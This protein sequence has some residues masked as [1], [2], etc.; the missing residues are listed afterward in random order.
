MFQKLAEVQGHPTAI[1]MSH[2]LTIDLVTGSEAAIRTQ[3]LGV[4]RKIVWILKEQKARVDEH[5]FAKRVKHE[6]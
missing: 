3:M 4:V 6:W 2:I 1:H 5:T